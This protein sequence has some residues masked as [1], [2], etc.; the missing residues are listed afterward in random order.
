MQEHLE[1]FACFVRLK[2]THHTLGS[3]SNMSLRS[4]VAAENSVLLH[5]VNI[6]VDV[7]V[8]RVA[9]TLS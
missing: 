8:T 1:I 3:L 2:T 4:R 9:A 5:N 6:F 7:V